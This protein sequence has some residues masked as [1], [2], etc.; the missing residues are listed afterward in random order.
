MS[1][2]C[3]ESQSFA[4]FAK[5]IFSVSNTKLFIRLV[6]GSCD[7]TN[8]VVYSGLMNGTVFD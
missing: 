3:G 8:H 2:H 7:E 5:K 4:A 6:R 1:G